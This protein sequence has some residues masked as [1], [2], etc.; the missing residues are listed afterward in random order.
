MRRQP[1]AIPD[2]S[3]TSSV[4]AG[5]APAAHHTTKLRAPGL[6]AGP[7]KA[8]RTINHARERRHS[9]GKVTELPMG[10]SVDARTDARPSQYLEF[11]AVT[12]KKRSI[13]LFLMR[14]PALIWGHSRWHLSAAP[15]PRSSDSSATP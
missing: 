14:L 2:I 1:Q 9:Y 8:D 6:A 11:S 4:L 7:G 12:I 15:T 5:P 13:A 10:R 3:A